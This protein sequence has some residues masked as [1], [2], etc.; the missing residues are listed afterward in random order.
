MVRAK[1]GLPADAP[2]YIFVGRLAAVKGVP[3]ILEALKAVQES[4]PDVLLLIVGDGEERQTLERLV[5]RLRLGGSVRFLGMRPPE[6]VA[7]LIAC[8][9]AGL[10]ASYTEGFSVA[11][12][13]QLACGRPIVTTDVSG[14]HDL[15]VDGTN[16]FILP[17]RDPGAYAQRML[18]VLHLP[19]AEQFGRDLAVKSFS[20]ESLWARLQHAWPPFAAAARVEME[21]N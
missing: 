19:E 21:G 17:S 13:E 2:I 8:A 15:I 20:R 16:G 1:L 6:E 7:E 3:L 11:M 12:V 4:R 14:A 18:D 5:Q 9:D 10:F